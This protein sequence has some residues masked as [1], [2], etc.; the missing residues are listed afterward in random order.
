MHGIYI[1]IKC[2]NILHFLMDVYDTSFC[3]SSICFWNHFLLKV[4]EEK[5]IQSIDSKQIIQVLL[6]YSTLSVSYV[7]YHSC[8]VFYIFIHCQ[9]VKHIPVSANKQVI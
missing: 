1:C 2:S 3:M 4:F 8:C 6:H 5:K 7:I 9:F